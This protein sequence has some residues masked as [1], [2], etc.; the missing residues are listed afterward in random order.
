VEFFEYDR[1]NLPAYSLA[2]GGAHHPHRGFCGLSFLVL[3]S[4]KFILLSAFTYF[5]TPHS[6][7]SCGARFVGFG[8][9]IRYRCAVARSRRFKIQLDFF[10][11]SCFVVT[12][13]AVARKRAASDLRSFVHTFFGFSYFFSHLR[14]LLV[15]LSA[16]LTDFFVRAPRPRTSYRRPPLM[17]T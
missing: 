6:S 8:A 2:F 1:P 13:R 15:A 16:G 9:P 4:P 7:G 12:P 5:E 14:F 10:L 17:R 3:M 11:F